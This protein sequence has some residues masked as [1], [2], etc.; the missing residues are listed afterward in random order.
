MLYNLRL[1]ALWRCLLYNPHLHFLN[2]RDL[3]HA[4]PPSHIGLELEC[5]KEGDLAIIIH[6]VCPY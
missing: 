1:V 6:L 4:L 5:N 2:V 3:L